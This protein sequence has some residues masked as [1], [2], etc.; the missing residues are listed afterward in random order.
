MHSYIIIICIILFSVLYGALYFSRLKWKRYIGI[1]N[2]VLIYSL[3]NKF[4]RD[5]FNLGFWS[6][7]LIF[8]LYISVLGLIIKAIEKLYKHMI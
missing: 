7:L 3:L 6:A 8:G 5:E 1:F 4:L 2:G